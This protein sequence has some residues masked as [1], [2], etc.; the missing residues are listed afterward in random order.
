MKSNLT[1]YK[2]LPLILFSLIVIVSAFVLYELKKKPSNRNVINSQL[3]GK[4]VPLIKIKKLSFVEKKIKKE[5]LNFD[6]YSNNIFAVNIYASWCAPCRVEAPIIENLSK[7]IPVVGIA[8][9]DK[10]QNTK[11]FLDDYGNPYDQI[12]LDALG[13][14]AIEWGVYGV[15]ETF[16]INAN[17]E[18]IYRHA[19]PLLYNVFQNEVLP[20]IRRK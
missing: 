2:I 8:Y 17:G 15:P 14:I 9:K 5:F 18:I 1:I 13:K 11:K 12:G 4:K 10:I 6:K 19:G 3:I 7:I 16:I 20:L